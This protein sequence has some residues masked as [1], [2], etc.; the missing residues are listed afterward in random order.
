M[1]NVSS[2]LILVNHTWQAFFRKKQSALLLMSLAINAHALQLQVYSLITWNYNKK[3]QLQCGI[4]LHKGEWD[5]T[6]AK[7]QGETVI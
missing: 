4:W 1:K 6:E 7:T 2:A 3:C 5:F